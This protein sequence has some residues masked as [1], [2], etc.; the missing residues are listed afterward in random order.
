MQIATRLHD[1]LECIYV[2]LCDADGR[3]WLAFVPRCQCTA[4]AHSY[5]GCKKETII[6]IS[7]Y[8]CTPLRYQWILTVTQPTGANSIR[9]R[10]GL[11]V[12]W[13]GR[14]ILIIA[15]NYMDWMCNRV[16]NDTLATYTHSRC[17]R[18]MVQCARKQDFEIPKWRYA[19][20][21]VCKS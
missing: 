15:H 7:F 1:S 11:G 21:F 18:C 8:L 13:H 4:N 5:S 14:L 20:L 10:Y 2:C 12:V 9:R 6:I 19:Y 17:L 3:R 16:K